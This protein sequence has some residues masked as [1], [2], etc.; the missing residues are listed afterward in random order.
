[1]SPKSD[2]SMRLGR[3][4][5]IT[6]SG[7]AM[8]VGSLGIATTASADI[9]TGTAGWVLGLNNGDFFMSGQ[10]FT[11][12]PVTG[13]DGGASFADQLG[14]GAFL[15][16][17]GFAA[18]NNNALGFSLYINTGQGSGGT[19]NPGGNNQAGSF[20]FRT[21]TNGVEWAAGSTFGTNGTASATGT[22]GIGNVLPLE[23]NGFMSSGTKYALFS[24]YPLFSNGWVEIIVDFTDNNNFSITIGDWAYQS[25]SSG[26]LA[27]GSTGDA[28][29]V[30]GLGGL[31]ALACGAAG[32]RS[33][34]RRAVA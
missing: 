27:A 6:G 8:S 3:Y 7:A 18:A 4:V 12:R 20:Y 21:G 2:L 17:N 23:G 13:A 31:A 30:P 26:P 22:V 11:W 29:A 14:A 25:H 34:R 24:S 9:T 19:I 28:P 16:M 32:V 1:M 15:R 33:K 5:I 10:S